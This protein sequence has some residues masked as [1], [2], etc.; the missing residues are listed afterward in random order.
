M[1]L[2]ILV[3]ILLIIGMRKLIYII[4]H[5]RLLNIAG[6]VI[7]VICPKCEAVEGIKWFLRHQDAEGSSDNDANVITILCT[8]CGNNQSYFLGD[9]LDLIF[10]SW[11]QYFHVKKE[12]EEDIPDEIL[13]GIL[14][15]DIPQEIFEE[16]DSEE[17]D[18]NENV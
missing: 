6:R 18:D 13:Q 11:S 9:S 2:S 4:G 3:P 15:N 1:L 17:E 16:N 8:K 12:E 5:L 10:P 7:N 14:G